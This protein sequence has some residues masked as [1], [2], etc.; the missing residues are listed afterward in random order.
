[1]NEKATSYVVPNISTTTI[2]IDNHMVVIQVHIGRNTIDDV[3]LDGG[4]EVNI[5][6]VLTIK[7][8][9]RIT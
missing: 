6:N 7:S 3:L 8:Q 4:Y 2:G 1:M 5:I 9:V